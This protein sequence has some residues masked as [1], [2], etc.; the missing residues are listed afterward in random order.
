MDERKAMA[1]E[2][3][4]KVTCDACWEAETSSLYDRERSASIEWKGPPAR[5]SR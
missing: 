1:T 3:S 2:T 4:T 5:T